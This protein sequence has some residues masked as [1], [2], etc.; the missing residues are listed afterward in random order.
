M[1]MVRDLVQV[2]GGRH[3]PR[4]AET[5]KLRRPAMKM[6]SKEIRAAHQE[7]TDTLTAA[8]FSKSRLEAVLERLNAQTLS[9]QQ[10]AQKAVV[11]LAEQLTPEERAKLKTLMTKR[12][13]TESK[14]R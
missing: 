12:R 8:S 5:F 9:A 1:K 2:M 3:D 10:D 13:D 6:R 4:V 14:L 11:Q 7:L